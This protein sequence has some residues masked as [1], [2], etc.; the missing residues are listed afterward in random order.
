LELVGAIKIPAAVP[1]VWEAL[2]DPAVLA[3]CFPGCKSVERTSETEFATVMQ[4]KVGP[5]NA[6]F[7]GVIALQNITPL[8][9]V[10]LSGTLKGAAAGFS[11]GSARITLS[12][13]EEGTELAYTAEVSV[14]GKL[15]AVGDRLFG[16][17]VR[18]NVTDFF[19]AFEQYLVDGRIN[20][21][22][23]LDNST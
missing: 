15:A 10:T 3:K 7:S 1:V 5:L 2:L 22:V 13:T 21:V 9:A 11:R 17:A 18:R 20:R 19:A 14:G 8:A 16:T 12:N 4:V 6:S 23:Q